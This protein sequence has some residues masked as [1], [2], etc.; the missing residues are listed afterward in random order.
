MGRV[1]AVI[2]FA[3]F[4]VAVIG[5]NVVI[6]FTTQET[7]SA[8]VTDKERVTTG[9]E[10]PSSKYLIFTEKETFENVDTLLAFKFN[11]SDI[12]GRIAIGQVCVFDV[13]GFRI[14]FLSM[15]RNIL[16]ADCQS[17]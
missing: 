6:H 5:A 3:V 2:A 13:V 1:I 7:V 14:P 8:L 4:F 9:G 10:K 12:Y 11:S 17:A 16:T 15:Y